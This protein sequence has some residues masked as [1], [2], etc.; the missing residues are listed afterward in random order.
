ME[1]EE[2]DELYYYNDEDEPTPWYIENDY[3]NEALKRP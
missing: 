2:F 3:S 1:E